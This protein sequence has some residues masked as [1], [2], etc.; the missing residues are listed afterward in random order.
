MVW[1]VLV[2]LFTKEDKLSDYTIRG[3][4]GDIVERYLY[5]TNATEKIPND[6]DE[7]IK[8]YVAQRLLF[9][10][11][12]TLY[13]DICIPICLAT[14]GKEIKLDENVEIIRI[15]E[16]LQKARQIKCKY[17][18][19]TEDWVAACATHM[20]TMANTT[21]KVVNGKQCPSCGKAISEGDIFCQGCGT[22]LQ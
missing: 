8:P 22:K 11:E 12:D 5:V 1:E 7:M 3:V 18:I 4:V 19:A 13:F 14:F 6:I 17:E 16:E 2:K 20:I 21:V 9:Y 15:S 10:L